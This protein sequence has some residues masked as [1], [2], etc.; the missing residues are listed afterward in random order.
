[1]AAQVVDAP[2]A[3][4]LDGQLIVDN[5]VSGSETAT[6]VS[7]TFPVLVTR[8][9]NVWISPNDAPVGTVSVVMATDF[10]RLMVFVVAIGVEVDDDAEVTAGPEGG[11]PAAVAVLLIVPA[12]TSDWVIV[13]VA[14]HV[15][16]APGASVVDGQVM[17]DSPVSGSETA[18]AVNVTLPVF[19][20]RNENVWVSPNDAPVGEVSVVIATDFDNAIAFV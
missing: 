18:T 11:V 17:L 13:R 4:V 8:N 16:D 15:V 6:A 1:M 5:P 19:V 2:G 14:A 9:E 7:V 20:T 12:L 3:R 10:V